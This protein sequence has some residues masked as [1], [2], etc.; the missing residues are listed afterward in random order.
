MSQLKNCLK[1]EE[2]FN[3]E[4]CD[5][6]FGTTYSLTT[7]FKKKHPDQTRFNN[8]NYDNGGFK[9]K[10]CDYQ[11]K[12]VDR[13]DRHMIVCNE[14]KDLLECEYCEKKFGTTYSLT[15]HFKKQ[16]PNQT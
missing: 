2:F 14:T 10:K 15:S 12:Q 8:S 3:C 11:G 6:R 7:H 1:T 16:H 13:L 4:V 5:L 9:C